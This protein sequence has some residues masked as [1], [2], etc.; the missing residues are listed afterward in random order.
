VTLDKKFIAVH[1]IYF[2]SV[3]FDVE[4]THIGLTHH[5]CHEANFGGGREPYPPRGKMYANFLVWFALVTAGDY[6]V[7]KAHPPKW[8]ALQYVAPTYETTIHVK[9]GLSWY[10]SCW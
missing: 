2:A 6:L 3:V 5:K 1:C 4:S 10:G 7:V 8:L 9:G